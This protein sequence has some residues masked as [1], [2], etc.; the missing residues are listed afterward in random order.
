MFVFYVCNSIKIMIMKKIICCFIVLRS[1]GIFA[2]TS[3]IDFYNAAADNVKRG[4]VSEAIS[5]YTQAIELDSSYADAYRSRGY[6]LERINDDSGAMAD[7][8]TYIVLEPANSFRVLSALGKIKYGLKDY[9]ESL[10]IFTE[11][12]AQDGVD[13][14]LKYWKAMSAY[15]LKDYKSAIASFNKAIQFNHN[16][17]NWLG[18]K[19]ET[20][21]MYYRGNAKLNLNDLYGAIQDYSLIISRDSLQIAMKYGSSVSQFT[22]LAY[23][24][25]GLAKEKAGLPF[26]SDYKKACYYEIEEACEAYLAFALNHPS[27]ANKEIIKKNKNKLHKKSFKLC[28]KD[29]AEES[30]FIPISSFFDYKGLRIKW[31]D[32][33]QFYEE[34]DIAYSCKIQASSIPIR[35]NTIKL[36]LLSACSGCPP[37]VSFEY[38]DGRLEEQEIS[39]RERRSGDVYTLTCNDLKTI[40]YI[41]LAEEECGIVFDMI[42]ESVE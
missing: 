37:H 10:K 3:A 2:Q 26:S 21:A 15:H 36:T 22:P 19:G 6:L 5:D 28:F 29:F 32:Y 8:T 24:K 4:F 27:E 20:E 38:K 33:D 16:E 1:F 41:H 14:G 11:C 39:L 7:Y 40:K 35:G 42:F 23:Y 30:T 9:S 18:Y 31:D 17:G 13:I 34:E 12:V 25:R